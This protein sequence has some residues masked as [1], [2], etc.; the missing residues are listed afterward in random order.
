MSIH[1]NALLT[2]VVVS[3]VSAVAVVGLVATA[4]LGLSA[5]THPPARHTWIPARSATAVA[6]C[7][8]A[9]AAAVVLFGLWAMIAR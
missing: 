1:W 5:R 4:L 7:C 3:A 9:G 6:G 2:V 8:L